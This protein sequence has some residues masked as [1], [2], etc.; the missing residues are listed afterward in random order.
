[1]LRKTCGPKREEVTGEWRIQ[2][3]NELYGL[4]SRHINRVINSRRTRWAR[5]VACSGERSGE[6]LWGDLRERDHLEDLSINWRI[7]LKRISR[8][9][10]RRHGMD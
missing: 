9:G 6:F 10:M 1:V 5:Y 2:H 7:I 3:K 8:S 4:Y